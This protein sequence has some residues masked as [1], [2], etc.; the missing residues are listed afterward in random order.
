MTEKTSSSPKKACPSCGTPANEDA[1]RCLVCG[2]QFTAGIGAKGRGTGPLARSTAPEL[3][4]SL[5]IAIGLLL[6]VIVLG[7]G[8]T[9]FG[10]AQSD[11]LA[12]PTEV[13][14]ATP[15]PSTTPTATP[16]TPTPTTTPQPTLTPLSYTVQQNDTCGS[17]AAIFNVSV[18]SI[19]L[20]NSLGADC[21]LFIGKV[22]NVPQPTFTPTPLA[23][24][25]LSEF[26]AT[27]AACNTDRYVVQEGDTL[28]L[29]AQVYGVPLEAIMEWNGL[30][31]DTAFL[32]QPL[33]IPLCE[34]VFV[35]GNTVTPTPAPPYPPAELLL[36][37]DGA[38]FNA[39]SN[40]VTLQWASV[41]ALRNNEFYQV[42]VI[43]ITGGQNARIID[44]VK[45]TKFIVPTSF[46]STD[47]QPHVYRWFVVP[48]AQIGVDSEGLPVYDVGGPVSESRV[49]S[50]SGTTAAPTQTP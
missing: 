16:A 42:T 23:T 38:S 10:L 31:A 13:P 32:G 44:E 22:L 12:V 49:F 20:E 28:S 41:G 18:Q 2:H 21:T 1:S 8:L 14:S 24:S 36:P 15:S 35:A 45:D 5:P 9:Y 19:L 29:I 17:I 37:A 43:D 25:T 34:R 3:R 48:V 33:T 7:G 11:R 47:G 40:T 26:E 50:W 30:T 39:S 6:F 46:R 4:L 27:R